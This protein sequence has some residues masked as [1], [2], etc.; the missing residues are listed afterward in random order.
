MKRKGKIQCKEQDKRTFKKK[1]EVK[2]TPVRE[3]HV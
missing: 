2:E 3:T 1:E